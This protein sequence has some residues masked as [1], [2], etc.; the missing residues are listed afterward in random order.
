MVDALVHLHYWLINS[1]GQ[2]QGQGLFHHQPE[3]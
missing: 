2:G 1:V 3:A